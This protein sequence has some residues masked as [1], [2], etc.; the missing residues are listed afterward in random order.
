MTDPRSSGIKSG[1]LLIFNIFSLGQ[2]VFFYKGGAE[3]WF[4]FWSRLWDR[5]RGVESYALAEVSRNPHGAHCYLGWTRVAEGR[6]HLSS[7]AN[8]FWLAIFTVGFECENPRGCKNILWRSLCGE[9]CL[10]ATKP[11]N[12]S[13]FSTQWWISQHF[14]GNGNC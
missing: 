9:I 1:S 11:V 4:G 6:L 8:P 13:G 14:K 2:T 10:Q 3:P 7:I 5:F 12:H